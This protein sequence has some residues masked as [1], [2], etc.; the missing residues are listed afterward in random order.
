[1]N[2][3]KDLLK[4]IS[5]LLN[6]NNELKK[7][8]N[9]CIEEKNNIYNELLKLKN[10]GDKAGKH[11]SK[12]F[13]MVTIL[14]IEFFGFSTINQ[15]DTSQILIDELD[16]VYLEFNKIAKKY[17]TVQVK[18]LGDVY[19]C[20]GGIPEKNSTNSID[21]VLAALEMRKYLEQ[22]KQFFEAK[23][24]PY[25]SYKI[26]I[27]TGNVTAIIKSSK[28]NKYE[29]KGSNVDIASR[30]KSSAFKGEIAISENTYELVKSYFSTKYKMLLPAK[31]FKPLEI[32]TVS[33]IKKAYSVERKG[34]EPN[35]I[36][37]TKYKLRQFSDLQEV[38]LDFLEKNL[39]DY[40]YYHNVK[41][42]IDVITQVELIGVVEGVTDYELLLLKTA[43]LFHDS[44]QINGSKDHEEKSCEYAEKFLPEYGYTKNEIEEIKKL[45]MATKLPPNPKTLTEKIMCDAD[46]DY[47]G[48]KDFIPVSETLFKELKAQNIITD[49]N[50]WNKIQVKFLE[51]HSYFTNTANKLREVNK[52]EQIERL[53]KLIV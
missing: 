2:N 29:V 32:F 3:N 53:K 34:L 28:K 47:L 37:H 40:L 20:V 4:R 50:E 46:L 5:N 14:F 48:R 33:R 17:K 10:E 19:L 13:D 21:V 9:S 44:G 42:T 30:I 1:M 18:T 25:W 12:H 6:E 7:N 23:D 51:S 39:P 24:L 35:E 49:K 38:I 11:E 16:L 26:G 27:H 8:I 36:F 22:R 31:Y 45:I 43:A 52:K 41:H 15:Q